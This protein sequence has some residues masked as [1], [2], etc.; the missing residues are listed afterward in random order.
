VACLKFSTNSCFLHRRQ[1]VSCRKTL[2]K[3]ARLPVP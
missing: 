2:R 1:S 3:S